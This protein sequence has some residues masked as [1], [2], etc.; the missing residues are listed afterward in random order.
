[1]KRITVTHSKNTEGCTITQGDESFI[2]AW[3]A[4][5]IAINAFGLPERPE[6]DVDG[7]P[8]GVTLPA[9]YS[10]VI[11]DLDTDVDYQKALALKAKAELGKRARQCCDEVWDSITGYNMSRGLTSE[12]IDTMEA[13]FSVIAA[14]LQAKRFDKAKTL[15]QA[16]TPDGVLVTTQMITDILSVYTKYGL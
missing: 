2:N 4:H 7:N 16:I 9:E 5:Q 3:I 12:Q 10:I 14:A 1:M 15:I 11:L 6:L 8:T 13:T